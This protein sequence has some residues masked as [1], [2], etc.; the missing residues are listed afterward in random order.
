[1]DVFCGPLLLQNLREAKTASG[2]FLH[3]KIG[4]F[5]NFNHKLLPLNL[6]PM[7]VH[8]QGIFL[9]NPDKN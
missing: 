8:L 7:I 4:S 1:V 6:D 3:H 9:G 5:L 2:L